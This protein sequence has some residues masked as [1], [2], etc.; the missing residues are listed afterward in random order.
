MAI[1]VGQCL[2]RYERSEIVVFSFLYIAKVITILIFTTTSDILS[3]GDPGLCHR[4]RSIPLHVLMYQQL[5][6]WI[7]TVFVKLTEQDLFF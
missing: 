3:E 1:R 7:Y 2:L 5:H 6:V 4:M